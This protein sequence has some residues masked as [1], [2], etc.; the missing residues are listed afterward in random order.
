MSSTVSGV[1]LRFAANQFQV[2]SGIR[3][4]SSDCASSVT[5]GSGVARKGSLYILTEPRADLALGVD[6]CQVVQQTLAREFY[7]D[8]SPSA[9]TSLRHALARANLA[10]LEHNRHAV[11]AQR[12]LVGISCA[13]LRHDEVY[14][15]QLPPAQLF[16][17]HQ[18]TI[19]A[20]P[21]PP[22]W[23]LTSNIPYPPATLGSSV[24]DPDPDI[25]H[26]PLDMGDAL[27]LCSSNLAPLFSE[28]D[29]SEH[30]LNADQYQIIDYLHELAQQARLSEAYAVAIVAEADTPRLS[31]R[32]LP[33]SSPNAA[34][35]GR[36]G[37]VSNGQDAANGSGRRFGL[38]FNLPNLPSLPHRQPTPEPEPDYQPSPIPLRGAGPQVTIDHSEGEA[39]D[40]APSP[41][42]PVAPPPRN[43]RIDK[44]LALRER[45]MQHNAAPPL[46][47]DAEAEAEF[48]PSL[49]AAPAP[50]SA[51]AAD[52]DDYSLPTPPSNY[53]TAAVPSSDPEPAADD[54]VVANQR[55]DI[56]P[57]T[58]GLRRAM[59]GLAHAPTA[60]GS[61][62]SR[63]RS[64]VKR[65]PPAT[66][67]Y[68]ED[69]P[70][71]YADHAAQRRPTLVSAADEYDEELAD[72][73]T[74]PRPK[75]PLWAVGGALLIILAILA[76]SIVQGMSAQKSQQIHNLLDQAG[77]ALASAQSSP[78]KSVQRN[79]LDAA[80][81]QLNA[82]A[83]VNPNDPDLHLARV[84]WQSISDDVNLVTRLPQPQL[85]FELPSASG[86]TSASAGSY[87]S[88]VL[89]QGSD[90]YLLDRGAGTLYRYTIGSSS[91][92]HAVL[93]SGDG[94]VKGKLLYITWR[95]D[96]VIA[97]DD[98]YNSYLY[99]PTT[100]LASIVALGGSSSFNRPL[101]IASFDGNLYILGAKDSQIEKYSAGHYD[102][103]PSDWLDGSATGMVVG[104]SKL[105]I[106]G[107]VYVLTNNSRVLRFTG[108]KLD[109]QIDPN[110]GN[111][112][113]RPAANAPHGLITSQTNQ[114]IYS[115]EATGGAP[116]DQGGRIL[117]FSKDG[118][119]LR[120]YM[121]EAGS[122]VIA[123]LRSA[124]VSPDD[125]TLYLL[126]ASRLYSVPLP[127]VPSATT[128]PTTTAPATTA[129]ATTAPA[130][131]GN[132]SPTP[133]P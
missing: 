86:V 107:S 57:L 5:G 22:H 94:T 29:A 91:P 109:I 1:K 56:S 63:I 33:V 132:L 112:A 92:A 88:A 100:N 62:A 34:Y 39:W 30:L 60:A 90:A 73:P 26:S 89:V 51:D 124:F 121:A 41:S 44:L 101:D 32:S 37:T 47:D 116:A 110:A 61:A 28:A 96:S 17:V 85:L 120:Q 69:T 38:P 67:A 98:Q 114:Y 123:D 36:G 118:K 43:P 16:L 20:F 23:P 119:L 133:L 131:T 40:D 80:G 71:D 76:F 70:V 83:K 113:V 19:R 12:A 72:A 130:A 25:V 68:A 117:R 77:A 49:W 3:R 35:Y 97:V 95:V 103:P 129:P 122:S 125:S 84:K 87:L 14:I 21:R 59:G 127:A 55:F 104:A 52:E 58:D 115:I 108:G 78:D 65:N 45:L 6:A 48:T 9:T 111:D 15:A 4:A 46:A 42:V 74:G 8:S 128:A 64:L 102:N 18:G 105:A 79:Y 82:A 24:A 126:T 106:D 50:I 13:A 93:A 99:N 27:I 66:V 75:V 54:E 11:P 7:A 2:I 10:L 53:Q 31:T 81:Q